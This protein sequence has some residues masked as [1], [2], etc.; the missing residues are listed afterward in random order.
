MKQPLPLSLPNSLCWPSVSWW[1]QY[2]SIQGLKWSYRYSCSCAISHSDERKLP[3]WSPFL[4]KP[5]RSCIQFYTLQWQSQNFWL[6]P[7]VLFTSLSTRELES[8]CG[9]KLHNSSWIPYWSKSLSLLSKAQ[10]LPEGQE[11]LFLYE[12]SL[13]DANSAFFAYLLQEKE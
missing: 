6:D 7:D 12:H 4:W 10:K 3:K 13:G 8:S 1:P 5:F 9:P 11:C 2:G